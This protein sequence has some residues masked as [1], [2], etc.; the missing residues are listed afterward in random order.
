M[1]FLLNQKLY[2][3]IIYLQQDLKLRTS[4]I[5]IIQLFYG[6]NEMKYINTENC[7]DENI[8]LE[9]DKEYNEVVRSF[10]EKVQKAFK[11]LRD[12]CDNNIIEFIQENDNEVCLIVKRED[13]YKYKLILETDSV[14]VYTHN[15]IKE[16]EPFVYPHLY[17][18]MRGVELTQKDN[19]YT[20]GLIFDSQDIDLYW[21]TR[22][23]V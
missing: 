13:S 12:E 3:C 2:G 23:Q 1:R 5:T 7:Y 10:D 22:I 19:M 16:N 8:L 20:L 21:N 18:F 14:V 15:D 17:A 11:V 9:C 6:G 4:G